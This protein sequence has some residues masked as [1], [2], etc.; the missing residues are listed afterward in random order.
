MRKTKKKGT[1]FLVS[2]VGYDKRTWEPEVHLPSDMVV[3]YRAQAERADK[4]D[5]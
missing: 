4:T 3:A 2:W 1:A 5:G